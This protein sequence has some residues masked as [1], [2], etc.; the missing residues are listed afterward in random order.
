VHRISPEHVPEQPLEAPVF[1]AVYRAADDR[2]RF[3]EMNPVTAQLVERLGDN[4]AARTGRELLCELA[5]H[6]GYGDT[7]GFVAHGRTI[8]GELR[9]AGLVI[10]ARATHR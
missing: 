10:G 6:I 3:L 4:A 7:G 8:L 2:V 1:L 5:T 9:D